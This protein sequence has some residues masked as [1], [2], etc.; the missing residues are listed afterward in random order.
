[1]KKCLGCGKK[2]ADNEVRCP[3]CHCVVFKNNKK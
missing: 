3:H 1:M 2:V